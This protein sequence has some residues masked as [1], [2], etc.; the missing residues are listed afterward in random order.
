MLLSHTL[1][2]GHCADAG[3]L[4]NR[5]D[6]DVIVFERARRAHPPSGRD[7]AGASE[8]TLIC[9]RS[10][11]WH[12]HSPDAVCVSKRKQWL[13]MCVWC[14]QRRLFGNR[15]HCCWVIAGWH[16]A[17]AKI[18]SQW[19]KCGQSCC[20]C[21]R[22]RRIVFDIYKWPFVERATRNE[23]CKRWCNFA[24]FTALCLRVNWIYILY[25]CMMDVRLFWLNKLFA[26]AM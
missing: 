10:C 26:S 11:K 2:L 15:C 8:L 14:N 18:K 6:A 22:R 24:L 19:L 16:F 1:T 4:T 5:P 20:C 13:S 3:L 23:M 25:L 17:Q 21:M 12:C 7:A 9:D